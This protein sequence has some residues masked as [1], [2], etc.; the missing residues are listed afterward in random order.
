M[1]EEEEE[2]LKGFAPRTMWDL[3]P[4]VVNEV[5]YYIRW[6]DVA[7]GATESPIEDGIAM[8]LAAA[9]G[10]DPRIR[11][12]RNNDLK[13]YVAG[14]GHDPNATEV[15]Y[16]H[17]QFPIGRRRADFAIE[18]VR[19]GK[20]VLIVA[21][22]CDG[23]AFHASPE[24]SAADQARDEELKRLGVHTIRFTGSQIF[25]SPKGC[26]GAALTFANELFMAA[27]R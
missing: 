7:V 6:Q 4:R 22:E 21:V 11:L 5:D 10:W 24:Q 3:V 14:I 27:P 16:I 18:V 2:A 15:F 20:R 8:G 25:A 19:N 12:I 1:N 9:A 13:D 23:K 26:A 17:R